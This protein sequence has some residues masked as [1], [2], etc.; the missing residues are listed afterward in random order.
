MACN[1]LPPDGSLDDDDGKHD[2]GSA[3]PK[4]GSS[5]GALSNSSSSNFSEAIATDSQSSRSAKPDPSPPV[6]KSF[7]ESNSD[8]ERHRV[9]LRKQAKKARSKLQSA[10][11]HAACKPSPHKRRR[12]ERKPRL[13]LIS[14]IDDA[15]VLLVEGCAS[16]YSM[17]QTLRDRYEGSTAHGDPYYINY[18]LM[19]IKY[20]EGTNLMAFFL[21]FERALKVTAQATDIVMTDEQK[22][23]YLYHA[24]PST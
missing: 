5:S 17:C 6:I 14:T 13:F 12:M 21:T 20:E 15:H 8:K 22:S 24:M 1:T 11:K 4:S 3:Q 16:A 10:K 2:V 23:I 18:F 19:T 7:T 9:S